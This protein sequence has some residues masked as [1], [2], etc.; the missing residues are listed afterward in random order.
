LAALQHAEIDVA[1]EA[2]CIEPRQKLCFA[3]EALDVLRVQLLQELDRDQAP[4]RPVVGLV[5]GADAAI[6]SSSKRLAT[7]VPTC[8]TSQPYRRCWPV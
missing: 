6:F 8:S 5:D 1:Y 3:L 2:R 4:L 7:T